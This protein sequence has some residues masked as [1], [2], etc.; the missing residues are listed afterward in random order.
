MGE[1]PLAIAFWIPAAI[2]VARREKLMAHPDAD[3]F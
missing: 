1:E 2:G 3:P